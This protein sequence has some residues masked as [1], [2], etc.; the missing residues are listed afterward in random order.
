[1]VAKRW[2]TPTAAAFASVLCALGAGCS[3][4]DGA[5][6]TAGTSCTVSDD[7][8]GAATITCDDGTSVTVAGGGEDGASCTVTDDGMGTKTI[9]CEDGTS[10]TVSDGT[11]IDAALNVQPESCPVCHSHQGEEH[12]EIYDRYANQSALE[13]TLGTPT[14][15]GSAGSFEVVVPFTITKHGLPF[16]DANGLPSLNQKTFYAAQYDAGDM[17]FDRGTSLTGTGSTIVALG[18]GRYRL[19]KTGFPYNPT[20]GNG[21]IYAYIADEP[22]DTESGGHVTMYDNVS[23]DAVAYGTAIT[24]PYESPANVSGCE[25]CHGAPYMKHGYRDPTIEGLGDFASCKSCHYDT[26]TGNHVDWQIIVNDPVRYAEIHN[27]SDITDAERT[28]YAYTANLMNDVHMAHAM[29]FPYPSSMSN[30][31]TCHE[32]KLDEIQT[33]DN[34]VKGTCVSCHAWTGDEDYGTAEHSLQAI[35]ERAGLSTVHNWAAPADAPECNT[36]HNAISDALTDLTDLHNGGFNP[37]IYTEDGAERYSEAFIVA[38]DAVSF[39]ST[40]NMLNVQFSATEEG[41]AGTIADHDAEDIVPTLLVGLYGYDTKDFIV[42]AHGSD[43]DGNRLL[44]FP[45]DGRTTNPRFTVVSATGASWEVNVDLSMWAD[46]ITANTIRRAEISVMPGLTVAVGE[47][48]ISVGTCD[49]ACSRGNYCASTNMCVPND[50][51]KLG[52][53]APSRTFDLGADDF[54][55]DFYPDIVDVNKCN[56]C[57]DQLA[58]TFHS[59]DRG[60]NIRVCRTCHNGFSGGSHLEMQSRSIDSYI[61]A[62]HSFQVFD[63][64]DIDFTDAV[65]ATRYDMHI[66]HV[67]PNFTVKNCEACHNAGMYNPPSQAHSLPGLLSGSDDVAGRRIHDVPAMVTG[68][69]SRACGACHRSHL[70]NEDDAAGLA[71]LYQHTTLNGYMIEDEEGILDTVI[72]TIFSMFE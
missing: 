60:G 40:S 27:G 52:L 1:M 44:E 16:I 26:R 63:P 14:A 5:A 71:S 31:N 33:V 32:G 2:M 64:G 21:H 56:T 67:F 8:S 51:Y 6:G 9:M 34:F 50:D 28:R 65:E 48:D 45:I 24:T 69:G 54:D 18:D 35:W 55:D 11:G 37:L 12:Q 41:G 19:T 47:P 39:D 66:E 23:S 61:H 30:C 70:I 13:L 62:I 59:A 72:E 43:D 58:T 36:C 20:T 10:A 7:G 42:S 68:P 53:N 22:L 15:S 4:E 46:M 29:E 49:P 3:G 25:N 57:H 17:T 38:I